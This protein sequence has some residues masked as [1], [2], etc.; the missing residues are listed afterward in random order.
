MENQDQV[1]VLN[2]DPRDT[3]LVIKAKRFAFDLHDNKV[4]Q[5]FDDQA[6]SFHLQSVV[7][8]AMEFIHLIPKHSQPKIIAAC[9]LHDSLEDCGAHVNYNKLKELFGEVVAEL[10]FAVTNSKGRNTNER[11]DDT[12]YDGIRKY[13]MATFVKLADR[14][15]NMRYSKENGSK[16]FRKYCDKSD[17]FCKKLWRPIFH[18]MITEILNMSGGNKWDGFQTTK[19]WVYE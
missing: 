19:Y 2:P 7:D 6:Y 1:T 14:I 12:Y 3:S 4:N 11:E 8:V 5:R 18:D 17:N 15:S 13:P 10:V 16:H 9:Y